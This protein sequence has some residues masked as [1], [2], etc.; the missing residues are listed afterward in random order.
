MSCAAVMMPFFPDY[1]RVHLGASPFVIGVIFA[2][3][4]ILVLLSS[5]IAGLASNKYVCLL[6]DRP[7]HFDRLAM[8]LEK[9][10]SRAQ[11]RTF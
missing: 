6:I 4:P 7:G 3:F 11:D 1:A 8:R 5:P 2:L 9:G 10:E